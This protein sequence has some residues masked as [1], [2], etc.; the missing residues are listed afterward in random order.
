MKESVFK[1]INIIRLFLTVHENENENVLFCFRNCKCKIFKKSFLTV[2]E[3]ETLFS[4]FKKTFSIS[5]RY[6][7][8]PEFKNFI[9]HLLKTNSKFAPTLPTLDE[10]AAVYTTP[11]TPLA[12]PNSDTT[13]PSCLSPR[14]LSVCT[15]T[16]TVLSF[17]ASPAS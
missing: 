16:T 3:N 14:D 10:L 1:K 2:H 11:E 15:L 8:T 5:N 13:V 17:V 4:Y 6:I 7:F 9:F 12:S